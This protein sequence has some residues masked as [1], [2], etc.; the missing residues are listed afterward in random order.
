MDFDS[1]NNKSIDTRVNN[2]ILN[3]KIIAA[4]NKDDKL[5]INETGDSIY[6]ETNDFTQAIR[7]WW[8]SQSRSQ[9]LDQIENVINETF[10][11]T[12]E[13]FEMENNESR[14]EMSDSFC[15]ENSSILQRF[16]IELKGVTRG[17]D[18]L[19][20]TYNEDVLIIARI[21]ILQE[22]ICIR[23]TKLNNILVIK[24]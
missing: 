20:L 23:T 11:L 17:L 4:L 21:N 3:L 14:E 18:N 24:K 1:N 15:E 2:N 8:N 13:I 22:R 5:A 10:I 9:A 16:L 19:K 7:R 6:I 12:D